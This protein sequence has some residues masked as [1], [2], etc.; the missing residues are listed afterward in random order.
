MKKSAIVLLLAVFFALGAG[1]Q[2]VQE[3]IG[4]LY[5]D[6]TASAKSTFERILSA[7]PNNIE[8]IYWLG[9]TYLQLNQPA[10]ARNVYQKALSTNGNAPLLLAGMGHV[11][12][13]E[14]KAG[15]ARQQFETAIN[16]SR[17]KKGED[18]AVLNAIGR[19]NVETTNGDVAYGLAKLQQAAQLA[20]TNADIQINLGNAYRRAKEGGQAVKAYTAAAANGMPAVAYYRMARIYETQRNWDVVTE[21]LNRAIAADPKFGPA[22]LR[23]YNYNLF[24]KQDFN[25]AEDWA[26]KYVAVADPSIQ[27]EVFG[28]QTAFLQ[29]NYDKAIE[30]GNRIITQSGST[31]ASPGVY[32]LMA[33]SYVEGKK[34]TAAARKYVDQLFATA[35]G[36]ELVAKDYTLKATIYSKEDPAQVVNIYMDAAND[37]TTLRNKLLILQEAVDWAKTNNRKVAEGDLRLA[38][39]RLNPN[40][41]PAG[42]FQIGLPYYQGAAFVKA[43][44]VFQAYS[45]ALPDSIY[46]YLW[47]ARALA[48]I[49]TTGKQGLAVPQ[50]E[51]VLRVSSADKARLGIYGYEAA[52]NLANYYV[53]EK[54]DRVKG[55]EMLRKALEFD[56]SKQAQLEPVIKRL[57]SA[58][59]RPAAPSKPAAPTKV[60]TAPNKTKVKKG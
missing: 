21:N 30:I 58:P 24:Y 59:A 38:L 6:R 60:K 27:N 20:P 45:R 35:K 29:K 48:N 36:D 3:G 54:N 41:S 51:Q 33:Y 31:P 32:R 28:A 18:P 34:D 13:V 19:A 47:S 14:N 50:Y 22:Y 57:E 23:Q 55:A 11:L 1:A 39:H 10:E 56:P 52:T 25:A 9:Q 5:A 17:G 4:H 15:E 26:R 46:G 44:S 12:L 43:D 40:S 53:N 49:D 7:N 37:D 2:S 42:L 8:A 16:L